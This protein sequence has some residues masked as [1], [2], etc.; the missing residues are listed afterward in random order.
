[1]KVRGTLRRVPVAAAAAA[2]CL[3]LLAAVPAAVSAAPAAPAQTPKENCTLKTPT[4]KAYCSNVTWAGPAKV[5]SL[6]PVAPTPVFQ[7]QARYISQGLLWRFDEDLQPRMDLLEKET[8]SKDGLTITSTLRANQKYSDGTPV[9]AAD[10]VLGFERWRDSKNGASFIAKIVSATATDAR[11]IVWKLSSPY[12]EF[13]LAM[14]TGLLTLNPADRVRSNAASYFLA[15]V[16]AGP[17]VVKTWTPGAD[18]IVLGP[19]PN[20]WAKSQIGQATGRAIPD[21][22]ARQLALEAG[23]I[24]YVLDLPIAAYQT[25]KNPSV[26]VFVHK[27]PGTFTLTSNMVKEGSPL[28]GAG[29]GKFNRQAISA[30]INR[31]QINQVAFFGLMTPACTQ[32]FQTN[33]PYFRCSLPNDGKQD[34]KLARELLAKAGN[35]SGFTFTLNPWNRPGWVEAANIIAANLKE[36]G[37]TT[38][39]VPQADAVAIASATSG[40]FQMQFTGNN[41]PSPILQMQNWFSP[42]GAWTTWSRLVDP[43]ITAALDRA[44]SQTDPNSIKR[45]LYVAN[46]LAY[47]TSTHIPV[48]DRFWVSG[49]RLPEGVLQAANPGDLYLYIGTIP[50]LDTRPGVK[51]RVYLTK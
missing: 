36:V 35:P 45:D 49:T 27:A 18:D 28:A 24:Q 42:G 13:P 37:I 3:G 44:A 26:R 12:P 46:R 14:A 43:V 15:P 7:W 8:V 41:S 4:D 23:T 50:S 38:N 33:N 39:V 11:T 19:N 2:L 17:M 48:G 21:A 51:E 1:M 5:A 34:L 25:L 22:A 30:A 29:S 9:T 10:A 31:E 20:Y 47:D 40:D 6:D 16:S 32:F